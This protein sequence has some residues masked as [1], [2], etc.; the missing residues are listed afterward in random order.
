MKRFNLFLRT[1]A[2]VGIAL[3]TLP[4]AAFA[5][6]ADAGELTSY[7]KSLACKFSQTCD[8]DVADA[9]VADTADDEGQ[10]VGDEAPFKVFSSK[11]AAP[12]PAV[13][14]SAP[15]TRP[16]TASTGTGPRLYSG[17]AARPV[18]ADAQKGTGR[19]T[20][21]TPKPRPKPVSAGLS[22]VRRDAAEM[23]VLFDNDS[24][25]LDTRS[26]AEIKAWSN[27]FAS[28]QYAAMR[29]RIEGHTNAIGNR[30]HNLDL[31]QR[32]ARAVMEYMVAQ[33]IPMERIEAVGYG[34]DRPRSN[35]PRNS[36]NR[37]VEVVKAE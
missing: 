15:V 33:G 7:E 21:V 10:I 12:A 8:A 16:G 17:P 30:D 3:L 26:L 11:G 14:T 27:V 23:Q 6:M 35:D 32:R 31:S 25:A 4:A 34:F 1:T 29:I 22:S 5:E 13:R 9:A 28:P 19:V 18:L 36:D 24:A 2:P 20:R 37:R